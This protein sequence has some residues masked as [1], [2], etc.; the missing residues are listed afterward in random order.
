[1]AFYKT[2]Y[3]TIVGNSSVCYGF[4]S[5]RGSFTGLGLMVLVALMILG[6]C[7]NTVSGAEYPPSANGQTI[8]KAERQRRGYANLQRDIHAYEEL[9]ASIEGFYP[10]NLRETAWKR[11]TDKYPEQGR[12]VDVGDTETLLHGWAT[13]TVKASPPDARIRILDMKEVYRPG[14]QMK[15]GIYVISVDAAN[16]REKQMSVR[17][18]AGKAT[19]VELE[20][21]RESLRS[22]K[23]NQ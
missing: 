16:Y 21:N 23:Y 5:R 8:G 19:V 13:L 10:L 2:C 20:L 6:D 18:N 17:L 7:E 15:H 12:G 11:L 1:M 22:G 14:M 3:M 4:I 9:V